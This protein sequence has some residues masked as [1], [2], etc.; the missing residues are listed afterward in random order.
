[1]PRP[2][3]QSNLDARVSEIIAITTRQI[4]SI[5]RADLRRAAALKSLRTPWGR[6]APA[7]KP[8][9]KR[10]GR[11]GALDEATLERVLKVITSSPGLRS[12]EIYRKLPVPVKTVKAALAKLRATKRVKT[13]GEK[14]AMTY[15]AR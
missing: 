1:M 11:R 2:R 7:A 6:G 14:R 8:G 3:K 10:R 9:A 15:A 13:K 12:E 5:V 4:V